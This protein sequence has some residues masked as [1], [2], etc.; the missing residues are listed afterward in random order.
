ME[1]VIYSESKLLP[2]TIKSR[3]LC[4]PS[5]LST[6]TYHCQKAMNE[7]NVVIKC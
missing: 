5:N 6:T 4:I 2:G 7:D 1:K 3:K